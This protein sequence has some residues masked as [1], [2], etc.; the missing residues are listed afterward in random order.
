[1]IDINECSTN[2]G[3]CGNIT[4]SLC[5]NTIGSYSC[6]C[7]TGFNGTTPNCNGLLNLIYVE[8]CMFKT[9]IVLFRTFFITILDFNECLNSTTNVCPQDSTCIN[10]VGSFTCNCNNNGYSY[11]GTSCIGKLIKRSLFNF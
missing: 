5:T 7:R 9:F 4:S 11:N 6:S 8:L 3:G 2:N 1:M 10:S